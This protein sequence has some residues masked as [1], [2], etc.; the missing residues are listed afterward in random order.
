MEKAEA[1]AQAAVILGGVVETNP[2]RAEARLK[3]RSYL[4]V[5]RRLRQRWGPLSQCQSAWKRM[6]I[7]TL[8]LNEPIREEPLFMLIDRE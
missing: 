8:D 5:Q 2:R 4:E 7:H 1:R 6:P 3:H